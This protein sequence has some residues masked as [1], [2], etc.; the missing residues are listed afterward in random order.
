MSYSTILP[1]RP[2]GEMRTWSNFNMGTVK[3]T[4][5]SLLI[6]DDHDLVRMGLKQVFEGRVDMEVAGEART[7][8]EAIDMVRATAY[9]VAL[10]DI[11]LSDMSGVDVLARAK[12]IRPEMAVLIVSGYPEEQYGLSLLKAGASGFVSKESTNESLVGAVLT[13]SQGRRYLSP[14]LADKLAQGLSGDASGQPAHLQLSD[15]EFQIFCRLAAGQ[16]AT[17]IAKELFLSVKTVST[18]RSRILEKMNFTSNA[19][20]TY[21]AVKNQLIA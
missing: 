11:S 13:V 19:D 12:A 17:D 9:D 16:T 20:I 15:R 18:Y 4:M 1:M 2:A 7:G 14:K 3:N 6:V 21:Y 10:V 8:K 5:I